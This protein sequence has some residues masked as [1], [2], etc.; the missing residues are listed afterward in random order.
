MKNYQILTSLVTLVVLGA[1]DAH[2]THD[3]AHYSWLLRTIVGL[4][5]LAQIISLCDTLCASVKEEA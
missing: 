1:L 3:G 4:V 2:M 5:M